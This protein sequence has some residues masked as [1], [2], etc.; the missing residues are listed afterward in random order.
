MTISS[1]GASWKSSVTNRPRSLPNRHLSSKR[2]LSM[3]LLLENQVL[4]FDYQFSLDVV[5]P[6]SGCDSD[7]ATATASFKERT[8]NDLT[9]SAHNGSLGTKLGIFYGGVSFISGEISIE[10]PSGVGSPGPC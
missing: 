3:T 9:Q 8:T 7:L 5:C 4:E 1:R 6:Q 2:E 10:L